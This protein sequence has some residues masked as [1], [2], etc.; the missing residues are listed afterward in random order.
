MLFIVFFSEIRWLT[1]ELYVK[2]ILWLSMAEL[3]RERNQE[4][5]E[6]NCEGGT[7]YCRVC[8]LF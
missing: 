3:V 1:G 2:L 5:L 4:W 6:I 8:L 7:L